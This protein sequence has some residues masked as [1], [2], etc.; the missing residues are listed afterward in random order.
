VS[1][2]RL[3]EPHVERVVLCNPKAVRGMTQ[4]G[5]KVDARTLAKLLA[6]GFLPE[7]WAVDEPTRVLRRRIARR[8]QSSVPVCGV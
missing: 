5:P 3:I 6:G 2:A 8:A 1:C 4:A 7:V